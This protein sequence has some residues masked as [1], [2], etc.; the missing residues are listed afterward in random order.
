MAEIRQSVLIALPL[1]EVFAYASDFRNDTEWSSAVKESRQTSGEGP[2]LGATYHQVT[3][4]MGR[5][6]AAPGQLTAFS[7]DSEVVYSS[8]SGPVPHQETR[9]FEA[10]DGG[11][12]VTVTIQV[13]LT[14]MYRLAESM[15]RNAGNKQMVADLARLKDRL[16][17][18]L[19]SGSA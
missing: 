14:G 2:E 16:E 13:E 18:R 10:V 15:L 6:M 9:T 4:F 3:E 8:S 1:E 5:Q 12:L 11:T 17:S 19:S 7:P